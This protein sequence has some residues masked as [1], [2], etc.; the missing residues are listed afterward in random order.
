MAMGADPAPGSAGTR[1][2]TTTTMR[3]ASHT[4][5]HRVEINEGVRT[6]FGRSGRNAT[7]AMSEMTGLSPQR[8]AEVGGVTDG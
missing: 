7:S 4:E 5:A 6:A 8:L 3:P 1:N 2:I